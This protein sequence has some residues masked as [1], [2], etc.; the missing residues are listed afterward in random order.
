MCHVGNGFDNAA[1]IELEPPCSL[2]SD[3]RSIPIAVRKLMLARRRGKMQGE[4]GSEAGA[5]RQGAK[6]HVY[7]ELFEITCVGELRR[8]YD[9]AWIVL[10]MDESIR[11]QRSALSLAR[12]ERVSVP[13]DGFVVRVPCRHGGSVLLER[14]TARRQNRACSDRAGLPRFVCRIAFGGGRRNAFSHGSDVW[15]RHCRFGYCCDAR[16]LGRFAEHVRAESI[17]H[18]G[19]RFVRR[20]VLPLPRAYRVAI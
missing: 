20:R 17:G 16:V 9:R 6:P 5:G 7:G 13:A 14:K 19:H 15:K 12:R 11:F 18:H 8:P 1:F 4:S 2:S 3:G 10:G